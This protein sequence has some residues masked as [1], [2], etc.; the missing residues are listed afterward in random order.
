MSGIPIDNTSA[1]AG[2][3]LDVRCS[4]TSVPCIKSIA[5]AGQLVAHS[6]TGQMVGD[7]RSSRATVLGGETVYTL[8]QPSLSSPADKF[9]TS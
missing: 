8:R 1:S 9:R 4:W 7:R 3:F 2:F 5:S 6:V